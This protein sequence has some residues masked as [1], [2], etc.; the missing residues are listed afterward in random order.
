MISWL[1]SKV[2]KHMLLVFIIFAVLIV[3][4]VV[5]IGNQGP[6]GGG[7]KDPMAKLHFFDTP[8]NT[9]AR[10]QQFQ[11]DAQL[12]A[13]LNGEFRP[14]ENYGFERATAL[15]LANLHQIPGP[16]DAQ[17]E[18]FLKSR[19]LFKSPTGEFDPQTY[20]MIV[21]NLKLGGRASEADLKRVLEED[22][23]AQKIWELLQGEGFVSESEILD[24]LAQRLAK[25][26]ILA[27]SADLST[28]EPE[29]EITEEMLQAHY[30][31][32]D[33]NYQTPARRSVS[34][35]TFNASNYVDDI[36]PTTDELIR[37]FEA[38]I[39][40][41]QPQPTV[42][43]EGEEEPAEPVT[44]EQARL[45]VREDLRLEEARKLAVEKAHDLVLHIIENEV[46]NETEGFNA[47]IAENGL[48]LETTPH[49][50]DN[51]TPIGT[52]W[53]RSIVSQAFQLSENRFYSEPIEYGDSV[54]VLFH[55]SEIEPTIPTFDT[56]RPRVEA[57]VRA[58]QLRQARTAYATE[59]QEKLAASDS[60]EAFKTAAEADGLT[61]ASHEDFTLMEPSEGLDNR[62]LSAIAELEANQ[63]SDI[64]R[65]GNENQ[66]AFIYVASKEVPEVDKDDAQYTEVANAM[67][68]AY[69]R[70]SAEQYINS[71]LLPEL[72]RSG[73]INTAN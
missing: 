60:P 35:V 4:F 38:N 39:D 43:E 34:Y 70:F 47:L 36:K 25:W 11:N 29:I 8:L 68:N 3:A 52:T 31:E 73:M 26:S 6:I 51:E 9:E 59:L 64:V 33:F 49:F 54:L 37:H 56:I 66:A 62:L 58:E 72:E 44:F 40:R 41:Y 32:F 71:L 18:E 15:H 21:D 69:S 14:S 65:L 2:Q 13:S 28:H 17:L 30:E 1:Q 7:P 57:D 24:T 42:N 27:A 46:Q 20:S 55:G 61:V 16:N 67:R 50:A 63:V 19:P 5:E 10:R 12:S 45:A 23:R 53:N 48:S 22:F